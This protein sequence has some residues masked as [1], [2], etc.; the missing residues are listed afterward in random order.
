MKLQQ[1]RVQE[2]GIYLIVVMEIGSQLTGLSGN[3]K[4]PNYIRGFYEKK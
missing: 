4:A 3:I 2:K 1:V